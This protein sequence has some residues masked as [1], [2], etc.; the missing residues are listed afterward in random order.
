ML[1]R[2][3]D[4]SFTWNHDTFEVNVQGGF[5]QESLA[6]HIPRLQ[7]E[8]CNRQVNTWKRLEVWDQEVLGTPEAVAAGKL[9]Y[10]WYTDH[11]CIATAVVI[12]NS[13]QR[14]LI[15]DI[16]KSSAAVFTDIEQ[17]RQWLKQTDLHSANTQT[18]ELQKMVSFI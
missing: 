2:H 6:Y 18:D 9:I 17:A 3:G 5:N 4:I 16:F 10:D 15:K 7:A 12:C 14:Q 11:G 8:V 1:A 13:L